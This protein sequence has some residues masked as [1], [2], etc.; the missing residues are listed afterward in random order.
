M[1][2]LDKGEKHWSCNIVRL[3]VL[4]LDVVLIFM[5]YVSRCEVSNIMQFHSIAPPTEENRVVSFINQATISALTDTQTKT[6][7]SGVYITRALVTDHL[8]PRAARSCLWP[9]A[10]EH[11]E[12]HTLRSAT[13]MIYASKH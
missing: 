4:S 2:R 10:T 3:V 6:G 5:V 1:T 11:G 13:M 8:N 9:K 12:R 7:T